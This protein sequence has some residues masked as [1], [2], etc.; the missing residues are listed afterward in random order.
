[1]P[2][3]IIAALIGA[4]VGAWITYRF[5]LGLI[6]KQNSMQAA[7]DLRAAF[8]PTLAFVFIAKR[9][10]G[11]HDRPDFNAHLRNAVLSHGS[12][13]E[14]FRPFVSK[15]DRSA[16]QKAWEEYQQ[17][18]TK[19]IYDAAVEPRIE[20]VTVEEFIENKIHN[21]LKHAE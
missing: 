19:D 4:L 20:G 8:A 10:I 5:S 15:S 3:E 9:H 12:A 21:I 7:A 1:M 16:Y 13:I 2:T 11:T 18:A 17:E 14:M 6:A